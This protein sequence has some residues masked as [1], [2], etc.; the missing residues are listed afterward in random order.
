MSID[1]Q[2]ETCSPG[3][4]RTEAGGP[5]KPATPLNEQIRTIVGQIVWRDTLI[6]AVI[7]AVGWCALFLSSNWLQFLAGIVPVS[8][9][10]FLGRRLKDQAVLH[11]LIL[12]VSGFLLGLGIMVIYG[13]LGATGVVPMPEQVIEPGQPPV[14]LDFQELLAF[15]V[16][17]SLF[18]MIPFPMFGTMIAHR[19]EQKRRDMETQVARRG[20]QLERP[21]VVRTL[22]DIR[23]LSLPQFGGYIKNLFTKH[24]FTYQNYQFEKDKYLDLFL[25]YQGE[26]YLLRLSVADRV[27]SG[28]VEMLAQDLQQQGIPKGIVITSTEFAADVNKSARKRS[29]ILLIDGETLFEIAER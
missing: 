19:N 26:T 7:M 10:I 1:I 13:T 28:M 14:V 8:T 17:F 21:P 18:A 23:G 6:A 27:R 9:G 24:Q 20:G 15:Y 22:E 4:E 2:K 12:G 11:G 29:N 5:A 16:Q 25:E 3:T